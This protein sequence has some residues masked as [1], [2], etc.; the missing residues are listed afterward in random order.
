MLRP[1]SQSLSLRS[2]ISE[3]SVSFY[4]IPRDEGKEGTIRWI[5]NITRIPHMPHTHTS[6]TRLRHGSQKF[7]LATYPPPPPPVLA[8]SPA[9]FLHPRS[10][11]RTP[12]TTPLSG[13]TCRSPFDYPHDQEQ[14]YDESTPEFPGA[15]NPALNSE[16]EEDIKEDKTVKKFEQVFCSPSSRTLSIIAA[17]GSYQEGVAKNEVNKLPVTAHIYEY[18]TQVSI[19]PS[20]LKISGPENPSTAVPI[21]V[22]LCIKEKN[23][24]KI[25]SHRCLFSAFGPLPQLNVG[26]VRRRA[27]RRR[28]TTSRRRSTSTPTSTAR[29]A[30][31]ILCRE[32]VT[33]QGASWAR[34][35]VTDVPDQV[36]ELISQRR[37]WLNGYF[38]AAVHSMI[39][40]YIYRSAHTFLRK[41]GIRVE[42]PY[43]LIFSQWSVLAN[44]YIAFSILTTAME[45]H[46]LHI[47]GIK[48]QDCQRHRQL[49]L[50]RAAHHVF[51]PLAGTYAVGLEVGGGIYDGVCWVCGCYGLYTMRSYWRSKAFKGVEET[52]SGL[53]LGDL[54]QEPIF[55][56]LLTCHTAVIL[57]L[58]ALEHDK[59]LHPI[60][61]LRAV[62][63]QRSQLLPISNVHDVPWG[64]KGEKKPR[65]DLCKVELKL[66]TAKNEVEVAILT[67]K[68]DINPL[69][70]DAI[71]R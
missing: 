13:S 1:L 42:M 38:F 60:S 61:A 22:F 70:E 18:T 45:D 67:T 52:P 65:T 36:P 4:P 14:D 20:P 41:F 23:Q 29:A 9:P 44:Y 31:S 8:P 7:P 68:Q 66:C 35:Y 56:V 49:V 64:T 28:Y 46:T 58:R 19:F 32:L 27:A 39:P 50:H 12:A 5:L 15:Y 26:G 6:P 17:M 55:C 51:H 63:C 34:H 62:L 2:K 25:N 16:E 37:C 69:H 57:I 24:K 33:K 43:S 54:L 53:S 11:P 71:L 40:F 59:L 21:Q 10:P 30:R 3:E 47:A 48:I